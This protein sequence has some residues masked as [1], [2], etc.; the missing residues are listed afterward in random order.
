MNKTILRHTTLQH[1]AVVVLL[2]AAACS[3]LVAD[4]PADFVLMGGKVYTVNEKQPWVEAVAVRGKKIVSVGSNVDVKKHVGDKTKVIDLDGKMLLPGFIESHIHPVAGAL[5]TPGVDLQYDSVDEVLK[6]VRQYAVSNPDIDLI[7]G[8]GWRYA[9][10]PPTGPT[11]K[12]LDEIAPDRPVFLYAIDGHAAWANSKALEMAGITRDTPDPQPGFSSY[13]RDPN[14]K[15]A[16]GYLIEVP[17]ALNVLTKLQP[18]DKQTVAAAFDNL[19]P[20]FAAAGI[21]TAFDAGIQGISADDGFGIYFDMEKKGKLLMRIVGSFYHNNPRIDPLPMIKSYC[22]RFQSELVQASI[23]KINIDGGD[24]QH[25]GAYLLP[26][27]DKP[28]TRGDSIFTAQQLNDIVIRA[29]AAGID[30]HYHSFGDRAVRLG[31]DAIEAAIKTNPKR[32]RRHTTGHTMYIHDDDV[33]RFA[34]LGVLANFSANWATPDSANLDIAVTR[35]GGR[36]VHTEFMRMRSIIDAGGR[37]CFGTDY[38]AAGYYSTYK[39][40]ETIQIA[41]TRKMLHGEGLA[42]VMPPADETLTLEQALVAQT[43]NCAYMLHMEDKIGSIE[44]GKLADLVVLEKN[45]FDVDPMDI[46]EVKVSMT[47]MNGKVTHQDGG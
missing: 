4:E 34:E 44:V 24:A 2:L 38:P 5:V 1:T 7:R 36:V 25:T 28:I 27:A 43:L 13:E 47:M 33:P 12:M 18:Q 6:A 9:L 37:V 23:L 22:R 45:L 10:F 19:M 15:E 41:I 16:T 8:F 14:T 29:D 31:L 42:P 46:S 35:L 30:V 40:L 32:D 21:T 39:P 26:Y 20:E 17:A 11:R 3:A